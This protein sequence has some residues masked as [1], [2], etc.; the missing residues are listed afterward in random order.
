MPEGAPL[1]QEGGECFAP[2]DPQEDP[3][4]MPEG[5]PLGQEGGECFAP[6]PTKGETCGPLASAR[7]GCEA[8]SSLLKKK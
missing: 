5:P 2:K 1:G 6:N 7:V 8:L 4:K 3:R